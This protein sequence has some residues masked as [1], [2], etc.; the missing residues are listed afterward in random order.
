MVEALRD[1]GVAADGLDVSAYALSQ[2]RPDVAPFCYHGSLLVDHPGHYALVV[3]L[4]VL[5][6]LP[7]AD[8]GRAVQTLVACGDRVLF[9]ASPDD[10]DEP[11]H[12]NVQP[13]AYWHARFAEVGFAPAAPEP[14]VAP[15]AHYY[16]RAAGQ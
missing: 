16:I 1:R 13:P 10:W 7:P 4:E 3:C 9:S 5:E 8:A 14:T 6:H 2:V 11:T 15:H 12:Q